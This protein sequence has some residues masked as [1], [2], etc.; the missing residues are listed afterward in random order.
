MRDTTAPVGDDVAAG[1]KRRTIL[2][3]AAWSVPVIAVATASPAF[4]ATN[5]LK[6]AFDKTSYSGKA[7]GTIS[8]VKVT[9]TR[10]NVAAPGE[11][12]TV[13]LSNGYTF[14]DGST[15]YTGT[16][17]ADGSITLPDIKVPAK[18]GDSPLS[19][20][21]GSTSASSTATSPKVNPLHFEV[22][23]SGSNPAQY[24]PSDKIPQDA[25][26][27]AGGYY[28]QSGSTIYRQDG[29]V[30][31]TDAK[32]VTAD[33]NNWGDGNQRN[34]AWTTSKGENKYEVWTQGQD[35]A[36]ADANSK[37][38]SGA[39]PLAAGYYWKSGNT[40]Y[41]QDGT[42]VA[43]DVD[44]VSADFTNWGTK[45]Q[46][47]I[48][49]TNTSG[50]LKEEVW[51]S[52]DDP[53]QGDASASGKIPDKS[54]PLAGGLYWQDGKTIYRQDGTKVT[55][56]AAKVSATFNNWGT[57]NQSVVAWTDSD[58]KLHN[59]VHTSGSDPSAGTPSDKIP[60][61]A[62]PLAGGIYWQSGTTIYRGDDGS[63]AAKDV[64]AVQAE[65]TNWGSKNQKIFGWRQKLTC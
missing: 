18:G 48:A 17:G 25:T 8:G 30:A 60:S 46:K 55:T 38:P 59:E 1:M 49:W 21:S 31:T 65:Y 19:A 47:R 29:T 41:R 24:Q 43:E 27:L 53:S 14:S 40:V 13:T 58:G 10:N 3:G 45:N 63:I 12:I 52:G 37:I 11:S 4:A 42:K 26:P 6:L 23:T 20:T 56:D 22:F 36:Q 9:A 39:T 50:K 16:S 32:T 57:A 2:A 5:D 7:C 54:T 33:F 34:L 62:T 44:T 51:T 61:N 15:S 64:E 28:W 35:P